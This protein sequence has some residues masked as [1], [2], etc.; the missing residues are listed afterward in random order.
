VR[1]RSTFHTAI[2]A[3][4]QFYR[5]L[6][7][8]AW[9]LDKSLLT[10]ENLGLGE[11]KANIEWTEMASIPT[12]RAPFDKEALARG[13]E[14]ITA[15]HREAL[16]CQSTGIAQLDALLRGGIPRGSLIEL[17]GRSSSGRTGLCFSLLAQATGEQRTC[18]FVDVGDSLDPMSLAAA[19]V[20]LTRLLWVRCGDGK[21]TLL[22][23]SNALLR[24]RPGQVRKEK[25]PPQPPKTSGGSCGWRHPRDQVRGIENAITSMMRNGTGRNVAQKT[26]ERGMAARCVGEQVER[27]R[28]LPRRGQNARR[29]AGPREHDQ[30]VSP[31]NDRQHLWSSRKPW[32][33]LDQALRT[34]DLLLHS[35]GWGVVVLDFGNV[36]WVDVRRIPLSTWF[37]FQ[38]IVEGTPAILLLLGEEPC[39]KSCA[40]L[41]LRCR[42]KSDEWRGTAS[43]QPHSGMATLRGFEVEVEVARSR[44][45]LDHAESIRWQA[46]RVLSRSA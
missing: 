3:T 25:A 44:M 43:P 19:G 6:L 13:W 31:T 29:L 34:T 18:A 21:G 26:T 16:E 38:R 22:P 9:S 46:R 17:N 23:H 20:D 2:A 8:L 14:G 30:V 36:S 15:R 39:A 28:E 24:S 7:T 27:D 4:P 41:A 32:K 10:A 35:G 1:S 5:N 33:R 11:Q 12:I 42:R 37:R 45:R 40:S